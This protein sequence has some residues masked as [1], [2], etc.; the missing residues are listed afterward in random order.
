MTV[1]GYN[2]G[3]DNN[4]IHKELTNER[5]FNG[6]PRGEIAVENLTLLIDE[7]ITDLNYF[8]IPDFKRYYYVTNRNII[9]N[10]LTEVSLHVDVLMSF[11]DD[12]EQMRIFVTR[13][14]KQPSDGEQY[15]K[16]I[17][18]DASG[19]SVPCLQQTYT[20][21]IKFGDIPIRPY[22]YL[23]TVG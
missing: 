7:N 21:V 17:A 19:C 16:G 5:E 23:V 6:T 9:R 12:I 18:W 1:Y 14:N 3:T 20:N 13:T 4:H 11:V 15:P 2:V 10:G 8:Y 22:F